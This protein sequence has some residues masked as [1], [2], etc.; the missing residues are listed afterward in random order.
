MQC[1][2]QNKSVVVKVIDICPCYYAP[3]GQKPYFQYGCCYNTQKHPKAG[4]MELDL[5]FWVSWCR[6]S[7]QFCLGGEAQCK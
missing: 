2:G 7:M 4:Q 5:S 3:K 6:G 1:W